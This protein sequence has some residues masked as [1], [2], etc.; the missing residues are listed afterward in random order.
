MSW[1]LII[2]VVILLAL[3]VAAIAVKMFFKKGATFQKHCT[4]KEAGKDD[5]CVCQGKQECKRQKA[6]YE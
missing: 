1:Q 2:T 5:V 4:S 3:A 6:E